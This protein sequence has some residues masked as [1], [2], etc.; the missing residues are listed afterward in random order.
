MCLHDLEDDVLGQ[1]LAACDA[2][3]YTISSVCPA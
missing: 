3:V 1:I 2:Y